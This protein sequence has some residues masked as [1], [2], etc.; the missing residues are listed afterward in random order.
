MDNIED[1][2][3]AL[4]IAKTN[5]LALDAE[6]QRLQDLQ[7]K[8]E[9]EEKLLELKEVAENLY[10]ATRINDYNW[11]KEYPENPDFD[12]TAW[13]GP[14]HKLFL[15]FSQRITD[16]LMKEYKLSASQ[17]RDILYIIDDVVGK[18]R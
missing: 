4:K 18:G 9:E 13:H 15:T 16:I 5:R 14:V 10:Y 8:F 12:N 6:I 1:V 2:L 3:E 11:D 17:V 7:K